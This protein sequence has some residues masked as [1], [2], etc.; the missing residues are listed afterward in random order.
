MDP[1]HAAQNFER[2]VA[3]RDVDKIARMIENGELLTARFPGNRYPMDAAAASGDE[4]LCKLLFDAGYE[5]IGDPEQF[6]AHAIASETL[7]RT[8]LDMGYRPRDKDALAYRCVERGT[9]QIL[10]L[11]AGIGADVNHVH[12]QNGYETPA[13]VQ[14]AASLH[15]DMLACLLR[16]GA[17][18]HAQTGRGLSALHAAAGQWRSAPPPDAPNRFLRIVSMLTDSGLPIDIRDKQMNTALHIAAGHDDPAFLAILLQAGADPASINADGATPLDIATARGASRSAG[19]LQ[20]WAARPNPPGSDRLHPLPTG[21][22]DSAA[23][24]GRPGWPLRERTLLAKLTSWQ[25]QHRENVLGKLLAACHSIL[26]KYG[27]RQRQEG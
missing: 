27:T 25:Q 16:L 6:F 17:N 3:F 4:A 19:V 5:R 13:I 20:N 23:D 15:C 18:C 21:A 2:F 7:V 9:P 10:A 12:M 24:P 14:A 26:R 1:Q 11:L 8:Y 22:P